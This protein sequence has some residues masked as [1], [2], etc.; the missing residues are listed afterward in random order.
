M[1]KV[2]CAN[3]DTVS[4]VDSPLK[5]CLL[6]P[7]LL[8]SALSATLRFIRCGFAGPRLVERFTGRRL[9]PGSHTA[10]GAFQHGLVDH[11]ASPSAIRPLVGRALELL[12]PD[13]PV[14]ANPPT[15]DESPRRALDAWDAVLAARAEDRPPATELARAMT[16][17][18]VALHGDRAGGE[19]P[20]VLALI[21]RVSGR[22]CMLIAL[23]R[24]HAPGP[25]AYRKAR[26]CVGIAGRIGLPVVTLVDT[27][28]ANPSEGSEARGIA[29]EIAA[30]FDAMLAAPVPVLAV[31]TGEGGSGGALA[32]ALGD[33][34]LA[35]EDSIFSVIG[36]EAAAE[37]LWR[38]PKRAPEAAH[39]VRL[40]ADSLVALGIADGIVRAPLEPRGLRNLVAYHLD[41]LAEQRLDEHERIEHRRARWRNPYRSDGKQ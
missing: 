18:Y 27:P 12:A 35:Y 6:C 26:R 25:A 41:R 2:D 15:V 24:S 31:V 14:R 10:V 17:G 21:A 4:S 19:D 36:P 37:I 5:L 30:L 20:G 38:D 13:D 11:V 3:S 28:G 34:L 22:R 40:T 39:L 23:D 1:W 7:A 32:F 8:S 9:G 33:I 16:D 29:W